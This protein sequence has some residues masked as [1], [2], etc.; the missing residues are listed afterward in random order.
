MLKKVF[1]LLV[2][3]ASVAAFTPGCSRGNPP[4]YTIERINKGILRQDQSLLKEV[5]DL[6]Q[7]G[8]T[9]AD[10]VWEVVSRDVTI[11]L[12]Q[13]S[14]LSSEELNAVLEQRQDLKGRILDE[15]IRQL[16]PR[17]P[18]FGVKRFTVLKV[19][20][21]DRDA[22]VKAGLDGVDGLEFE[23]ALKREGDTFV[24]KGISKEYWRFLWPKE[25]LLRFLPSPETLLG[26]LNS[27][28]TR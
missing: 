16:I 20:T 26:F 3:A 23:F 24:L 25:E 4:E 17:K 9:F 27:K 11:T 1:L 15:M 28:P 5:V 8:P 12:Q 19:N 18:L 6:E 22:F 14:K 7:V 13:V 21:V 2:S 10:Y